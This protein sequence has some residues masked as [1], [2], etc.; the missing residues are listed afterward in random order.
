MHSRAFSGLIVF[1]LALFGAAQAQSA[2]PGVALAMAISG[3]ISPPVQAFSEIESSAV[4][5]LGD[6][7]SITFVH[8]EKCT[9]VSVTGGEVRLS[10]G[11]YSVQGGKITKEQKVTCP[12]PVRLAEGGKV[13]SATMIMRSTPK[14]IPSMPRFV[15]AG[16]GSGRVTAVKIVRDEQAIARLPVVDNATI[17]PTSLPALSDGQTYDV[18]GQ[19]NA[20]E[21]LFL[22][23]FTATGSVPTTPDKTLVILRLK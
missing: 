9:M 18:Y 20:G 19:N 14:I 21:H 10:E 12:R 15:I 22:M 11:R 8:Y 1:A 3:D 13:M 5:Q 16:H 2:A 17:W 4:L 6:S 7:S 23:R